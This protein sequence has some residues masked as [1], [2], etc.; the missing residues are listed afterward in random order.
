[1]AWISVHETVDGPK[2]RNLYKSLGCSK[3]EAVGILNFLWFWGL[4][5]A[6]KEGLILYADS[7]DIE[8]YL[9]GVG[10]GTKIDF[11]RIVNALI[12]TGWLEETNEGFY[13]HDWSMWQA[14]WYKARERRES[15]VRRKRETA[16]RHSA[17]TDEEDE[18]IP[19]ES[20]SGIPQD[21]NDDV[22]EK[23]VKT[24]N[25]NYAPKFEEF[26]SIYPRKIGKGEAYRKYQTR[27]KDGFSDDELI[28]AAKN[29][30][31]QCKKQKTERQFIKHPKTFL[32]DTLPFLDFLP[33]K[34]ASNDKKEDVQ[35]GN[36]FK[37]WEGDE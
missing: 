2:L 30:D 28:T 29:Y 16:K 17:R 37:N 14:P 35:T 9:Y 12:E 18:D 20:P 11:K 3:F 13:L 24:D 22:T 1:M 21:T 4:S 15:D 34:L 8:R 23:P 5:N 36:P 26:W 27:R 32:S 33:E 6:T 10:T 19:Q 31:L 25:S 7:E